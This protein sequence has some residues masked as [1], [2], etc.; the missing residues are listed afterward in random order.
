MILYGWRLGG[1]RKSRNC[2]QEQDDCCHQFANHLYF[3]PA[4]ANPISGLTAAAHFQ[5]PGGPIPT[6]LRSKP[7]A[8]RTSPGNLFDLR[9][10]PGMAGLKGTPWLCRKLAADRRGAG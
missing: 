6:V 2:T 4:P 7:P 9:E 10:V 5:S 3:L 1:L 8:I